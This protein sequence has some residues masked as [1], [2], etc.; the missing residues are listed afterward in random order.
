MKLQIDV[1]TLLPEL[2][3]SVISAGI[4][5]RAHKLGLF[6]LS[7]YNPRD[8]VDDVHKTVDDRPFGGG[9][10][11]VMKYAP[12]KACLDDISA[13]HGRGRRIYLSPQGSVLNQAL[14]QELSCATHLVLLCGR[15]E[16]VD[17]RLIINEIDEEIS[18][19][20]YV[21]SGGELGA[22]VLIDAIARLIPGALNS[23]LS[24][25]EDSFTNSL[26]DHPHYTRPESI[27]GLDVPKVLLSGD[28]QK[29]KEWRAKIALERTQTR[30][31]DLLD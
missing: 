22:A 13:K 20:D 8:Y 30:R 10:G 28:H 5:A 15:Y 26:L 12:L 31:P 11:M 19:G 21:L 3:L 4:T 14:A 27:N 24:A 23:N 17:E 25:V 6:E 16:G 1:I 18:I 29:I 2:V 7:T 9:P